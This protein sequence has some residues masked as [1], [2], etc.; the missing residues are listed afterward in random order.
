VQDFG[1]RHDNRQVRRHRFLAHPDRTNRVASDDGAVLLDLARD[2]GDGPAIA[3]RCGSPVVWLRGGVA[4][5][6]R[7]ALDHDGELAGSLGHA[8]AVEVRDDEEDPSQAQ[9]TGRHRAAH[10]PELCRPRDSLKND[11]G[12]RNFGTVRSASK[13]KLTD[14]SGSVIGHAGSFAHSTGARY[15]GG[16]CVTAIIAQPGDRSWSRWTGRPRQTASD[17]LRASLALSR[18]VVAVHD[19]PRDDD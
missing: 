12:I 19:D 11:A 16:S 4:L 2:R 13:D 6:G 3:G 15:T 18:A 9:G 1:V 5:G 10:Q 14:A 17:F 8:P 7:E